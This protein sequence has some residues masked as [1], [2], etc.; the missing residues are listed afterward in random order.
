MPLNPF[1]ELVKFKAVCSRAM[2][3]LLC[4]IMQKLTHTATHKSTEPMTD[5]ESRSNT[6]M[7]A[8]RVHRNVKRLQFYLWTV[9]IQ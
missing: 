8:L 5:S 7:V 3:H 4:D 9:A 6:S 1:F 2:V